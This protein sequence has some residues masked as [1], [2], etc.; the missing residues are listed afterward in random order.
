MSGSI[1][2]TSAGSNTTRSNGPR[3]SADLGTFL[4]LLTTQLR[5]QDPSKPMD[6]EQLTQ[7]L[8]QF[9]T[10]E[11]QLAGNQ[12]LQSL[13]TLQQAGQL[14]ES[15]NLIGRR[16]TVES[17]TLPLQ[18]GRAEIV[19]PAAGQA[20]RAVVEIRDS[21][22]LLVRSETVPL[23]AA[24]RRW[25]WDG[26]ASGG[27]QRNDGAYSVTVTGRAQDGTSLPLT[28]AVTGEVTGAARIDGALMLRLGAATIGFDRLRE[29]PNSL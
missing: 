8:V 21:A 15:A 13:L 29:L 28:A 12:T 4:T 25:T 16:V 2:A 22:G 20:Q 18:G 17:D 26:R 27:R 9:A 24:S 10:V 14:A 6:T 23:S 3:L 5:N 1:S 11:Q 7:Q 19:L